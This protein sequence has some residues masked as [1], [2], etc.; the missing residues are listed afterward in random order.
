[1]EVLNDL[2]NDLKLNDLFIKL[3]KKNND[4]NEIFEKI[5]NLNIKMDTDHIKKL[6]AVSENLNVVND[7]LNE[8]YYHLIDNDN[9]ISKTLDDQTKIKDYKID[10]VIKKT[11]LPYMMLMKINLEN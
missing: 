5:N 11:F 7:D 1:M 4:I 3:Q 2:K 6:S 10:A 9:T 8:I